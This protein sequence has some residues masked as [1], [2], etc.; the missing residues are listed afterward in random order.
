MLDFEPAIKPTP[1]LRRTSDAALKIA[2]PKP[3]PGP[4]GGSWIASISHIATTTSSVTNA[5]AMP[6]LGSSRPKMAAMACE[7]TTSPK[8]YANGRIVAFTVTLNV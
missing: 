3:P 5:I 6:V 7:I 4:F 2:S 8:R 1:A